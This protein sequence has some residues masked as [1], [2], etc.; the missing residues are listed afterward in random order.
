MAAVDAHIEAKRTELDK[1]KD[2]P[3]LPT[4]ITKPKIFLLTNGGVTISAHCRHNNDHL[5]NITIM[6][7]EFC[8]LL[9][10]LLRL[11]LAVAVSYVLVNQYTAMK[12]EG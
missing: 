2:R 1:W 4:L 11:G 9:S 12:S 8:V 3:Q 7:I 10:S 5:F 6:H